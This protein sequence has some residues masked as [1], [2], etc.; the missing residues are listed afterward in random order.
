M[1][2][3]LTSLPELPLVELK[4]SSKAIMK[5]EL[6]INISLKMRNIRLYALLMT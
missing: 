3:P 1:S 4:K 6:K 2:L 5:E